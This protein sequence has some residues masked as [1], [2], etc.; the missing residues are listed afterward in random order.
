[1]SDAINGRRLEDLISDLMAGVE[2]LSGVNARAAGLSGVR[3]VSIAF[4]LP[5]ETR[6]GAAGDRLIVHADVPMCRTRTPF[7]PPVGRLVFT[8]VEEAM[9]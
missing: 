4:D 1:M 2:R 9:S 5:V 8:V 3:P 6:I 7:D